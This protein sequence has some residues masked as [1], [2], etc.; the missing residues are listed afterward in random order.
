MTAADY[1][2]VVAEIKGGK[3]KESSQAKNWAGIAIA[4]ALS[5][6]LDKPTD[7]AKV[8]AALKMYLAAKTLVV[9]ERHDDE[10]RKPRNFIEVPAAPTAEQRVEGA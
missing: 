9:V 6:D 10:Q 3:W 2:K 7:K 8:K 4:D 1:D 5:L